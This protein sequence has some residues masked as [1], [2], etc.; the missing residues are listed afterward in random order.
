MKFPKPWFR[1]GR[2]WFVTLD[3]KQI[4]LGTRRDE[5][6]EAYRQLISEPQPHRRAPSTAG[7][8]LV[9]VVEHFLEWVQK[10]RAPDTY[11]WYQYRLE[12]FCRA[13]PD[14]QARR[15]KPFMV[16]EWVNGYD[17]SVTS[18]RNYLRSAKRCFKWAKRQGYIDENPIADLE[19][20]SAEERDIALTQEQFDGL[21]TFVRNKLG[22]CK[23][24]QHAL[25]ALNHFGE[26]SRT[27]SRIKGSGTTP[28]EHPWPFLSHGRFARYCRVVSC[29]W[30]RFR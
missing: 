20:P 6:F 28:M 17:L 21:M 30:S 26:S 11:V 24:H 19:V 7:I 10:H 25:T 18:Q 27:C 1:K 15:L 16:Q 9:E 3:G 2:G 29:P 23:I 4:K 13:Y 5:S 12:R 22:F 14:L 8:S